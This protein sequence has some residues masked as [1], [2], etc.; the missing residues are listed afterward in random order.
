MRKIVLFSLV[1]GISAFG[2]EVW[3]TNLPYAFLCFT[4]EPTKALLWNGERVGLLDLP[5][6]QVVFEAHVPRAWQTFGLPALSP[7]G[8]YLAA[9]TSDTIFFWDTKSREL[10]MSYKI[11]N[12]CGR[13]LAFLDEQRL[14]LGSK[15]LCH[16]AYIMDVRTGE[17]L[18]TFSEAVF[19]MSI[20]LDGNFF[21][22]AMPLAE[23]RIRVWNMVTGELISS[24]HFPEEIISLVFDPAGNLVAGG[25]EG[26][27]Y[28]CGI[29]NGV[30]VRV[31]EQGSPINSLALSPDGRL[32]AV[33]SQDDRVVVWTF[34]DG[35]KLLEVNMQEELLK[36]GIL[37]DWEWIWP[38]TLYVYITSWSPDGRMISV[39]CNT[40][41]LGREV[42]ILKLPEL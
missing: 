34:P 39:S 15:Y 30:V 19:P 1:L 41:S 14:F 9:A 18:K 12:F 16:E 26:K 32:L 40:K 3:R 7:A 22:A 42:F 10:A 6:F 35:E 31:F 13:W 2:V 24:F 28:I 33:S 21:A 36:F 29:L 11:P 25:S 38:K 27:I 20:S 37:P 4:P 23:E 5:E 8:F 17:I